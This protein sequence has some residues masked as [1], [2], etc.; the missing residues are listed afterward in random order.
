MA[1][2]APLARELDELRGCEGSG[3]AAYFRVFGYLVRAPGFEFSGRTRRPPLDPI[4][5][6]L[7]LGYT[8]LSN[9]VETAVQIVGLDPYLGSLHAPETGRPSL[10]CDLMEE[11]RAPIVDALVLAAV[12]RGLIR[13]DDFE[14][15][16]PGEPVL[17]KRECIGVLAKLYRQRLDG[18]AAYG[19]SKQA[20]PYREI[21]EQQVRGFARV[22]LGKQ[23]TYVPFEVR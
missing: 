2:R 15:A 17:V 12:N 19:A 3:A 5:A 6:L 22:M 8:F 11:Y 18:R 14:E 7:S 4:N 1:L 20:L 10:V 9:T 16:G 21:I 23:A 13:T